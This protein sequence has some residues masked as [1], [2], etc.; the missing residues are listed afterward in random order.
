M[1]Y[2][3]PSRASL[4]DPTLEPGLCLPERR[5]RAEE[6]GSSSSS[7]RMAP[8]GSPTSAAD[9][10]VLVHDP[11]LLEPPSVLQTARSAARLALENERLQAALRAE[12]AT[13]GAET[14]APASK[15]ETTASAAP[16]SS[17]APA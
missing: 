6:H 1:R 9:H 4:A 15:S 14:A 17:A 11:S 10:A 8:A 3:T 16:T 7:P 5:V 2:A 13:S 12:L